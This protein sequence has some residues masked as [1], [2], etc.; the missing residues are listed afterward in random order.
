MSR[1]IS[2][3][4]LWAGVGLSVCATL[5]AL[6]CQSGRD[7]GAP[8]GGPS[9]TTARSALSSDGVTSANLQLEVSK[10]ACA[11]NLAQDYFQVTNG[12]GSPVPLSQIS[13]KYWLND[14]STAGIVPQIWYGGCVT[15]PNGTCVH[16]V[17]GATATATRFSPACGPDAS[18]QA[19]WEITI[20]TTDTTAL[21]PGQTWSNLQTA[22][23]LSTYANFSPGS[24]TWFSGCGTGQPYAA[25]PHFAVYD[26]GD[27]VNNQGILVPICRAPE[28]VQIQSYI[29]GAYYAT[30][31]IVSSF[32]TDQ[33]EPFDCISF[34][35]QNSVQAWMAQGVAMPTTFP[36]MPPRPGNMPLPSAPTD[37]AFD[38]QPDANGNPRQCGA[39][40]VPVTRPTVAQ[41]QG[42]GG[43]DAFKQSLARQVRPRGAPSTFE[44]DCW[45]NNAPGD[46][47]PI[48][49]VNAVDWEHAVGI[50]GAGFSPSGASGFFGMHIV[51][52][53]YTPV[54]HPG[55]VDSVNGIDHTDTQL[56]AQTGGCEDWYNTPAPNT[57]N[58][59]SL[60]VC[61]MG[62]ACTSC[63]GAA[64]NGCAVQSL[65]V[66]AVTE[67]A[68]DDPTGIRK[69]TR[70]GVFFTSDGYFV[71]NCW[72][73]GGLDCGGCPTISKAVTPPGSGAPATEGTDCWVTL[74]GAKF[75]P[76]TLLTPAGG[77]A[78]Q[79]GVIPDEL[80]LTIWNGSQAGAPGWWVY[81]T[82]GKETN[83]SPIGWYPPDSFDWP[84]GSPGPMSSGPA[85][86]LQSGGEVF[87]T[88]PGGA[89]TDTAMVSDNAAQAGYEFASYQRNV[90][91]YDSSRVFHD[92]D[93]AFNV[94][95]SA[96]GDQGMPGICGLDSAGWTA[97]SSANGAYSLSTTV[98]SGGSN[99]GQFLYFGGGELA[100]EKLPAGTT[101]SYKQLGACDDFAPGFLQAGPNKA[102]VFF[103]MDAL[104]NRGS[105][106]ATSFNPFDLEVP[107]LVTASGEGKVD[108][109]LSNEWAQ[110]LQGPPASPITVPPSTLEPLAGW[111]VM[112]VST[113]TSDGAVEANVTSY[114]LVD[115]AGG[116]VAS[117]EDST[118]TSWPYTRDC[119]S[120]DF[121]Q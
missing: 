69:G 24:G 112:L 70:L 49:T 97:A 82:N 89:H 7:M 68:T 116:I 107:N 31:D 51:T 99:W 105:G 119:G 21:G 85:T 28:V 63:V 22:V 72:A 53:I 35:A 98:A 92:A 117:K 33:G 106:T 96:E 32:L 6:G 110:A 108:S 52:P 43:I 8:T 19:S 111:G 76:N 55:S 38:G 4:A 81:V 20:S 54:V 2:E 16:P 104:D 50:Q 62:S 94:A 12:T 102:Y 41:I 58:V 91:Y 23:N 39:G 48:G 67:N 84:D 60:N 71:R 36:S 15:S 17:T 57:P 90:G 11:G 87:N 74:P 26:N 59:E 66:V 93:L 40:L 65:E 9:V 61:Q 14:T 64:C 80:E 75:A 34:F 118:R 45:L 103:R 78:N 29:D 42:A 30:S 56:W 101:L 47:S 5:S 120:I 109:T 18:H 115:S 77:V 44:H 113:S 79:Y 121:I 25:D 100:K 95:P 37:L 3:V 88:W 114:V 86:Y 27:L 83:P 46:G 73:K 10:N 13:I 1:S